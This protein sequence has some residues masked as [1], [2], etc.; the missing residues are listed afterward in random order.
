MRGLA[1]KHHHPNDSH[2]MNDNSPRLSQLFSN[3]YD[4]M[5]AYCAR[6][7]GRSEAED[8]AAEVFAVAV[9]RSGEIDWTTARPW[10]YGVA[11]GVLANR[12]RSLQRRRRLVGR[13]A[14]MA[15]IAVEAAGE[16]VV[17]RAESAQALAALQQ[18]KRDDREILML[19]AWEEL[20][21][22]EIA[23]VLGISR[24]AADQRLHRA[25]RRYARMLDP[26][27]RVSGI[28]INEKGGR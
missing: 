28:A 24:V 9:R 16:L 14:G 7:V 11:R 8:V 26:G 17:R 15:P 4:E 20:S 18:M 12:W 2:G 27:L 21:G 23:Q 13:M 22:P 19:A 10:L 5:L 6:R 3:H 25:K 1:D